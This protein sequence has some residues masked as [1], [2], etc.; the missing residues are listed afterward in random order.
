M[1]QKGRE[2]GPTPRQGVTTAGVMAE[3]EA[4]KL[5]RGEEFA[6]AVPSDVPGTLERELMMKY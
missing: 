2:T 4:E 1:K 3:V 5:E 6:G